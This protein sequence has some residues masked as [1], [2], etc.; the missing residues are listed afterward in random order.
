[1]EG[2]EVWRQYAENL[3]RYVE[4]DCSVAAVALD[5]DGKIL[6]CNQ[7]FLTLL[8]LPVVPQL[9]AMTDYLSPETSAGLSWGNK[10]D[11]SQETWRLRS[12]SG[13][14]RAQCHIYA[15]N[16]YIL[17]FIDKPL[18]TDSSFVKE[19]DSINRE[20]SSL[21][22]ELHKKNAAI[23]AANRKLLENELVL[24][25]AAEMAFIGNWQWN[26]KT[27]K[28]LVSAN[29]CRLWDSGFQDRIL[30]QDEFISHFI[31]ED[32]PRFASWLATA[33]EIGC[34]REIEFRYWGPGKRE[35]FGFCRADVLC[36][37]DRRQQLV[38]GVIQ[39]ITTRKLYEQKIERIAFYDSLTGLPNRKMFEDF[40]H[41]ASAQAQRQ[42][43]RIAILLLDLDGF[44]LVNDT[45][46]HNAGDFVLQTIGKRLMESVRSGDTVARLGGDEFIAYLGQLN[47]QQEA[48][49]VAERILTAC[50]LPIA[51]E[52]TTTG[53]GVSIGI[54]YYSEDGKDLETLMKRADM[55]MYHSK[56]I[57]KNSISVYGEMIAGTRCENA[58]LAADTEHV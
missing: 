9:Q 11:Y 57:G 33:Q 56:S 36:D 43:G 42:Q 53:V 3:F 35:R 40:F 8:R 4:Q 44:K 48:R 19:F 51:Y 52:Q 22:R 15:G 37:I 50:N 30:T 23:E 2:S 12:Q 47:S 38:I 17:A 24:K 54:S 18:L 29:L 31:A 58:I 46:G 32:A 6:H 7:A 34:A 39:D 1:M 10:P 26:V 25:Q 21:S 28:I 14:Y 55:A 49:I 45:L 5:R 16:D 20:M 41:K 13:Y 27:G